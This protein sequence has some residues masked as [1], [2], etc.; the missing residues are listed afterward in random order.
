MSHS[1][2]HFVAFEPVGPNGECYVDLINKI[3]HVTSSIW[4]ARKWHGDIFEEVVIYD[5]I[6]WWKPIKRISLV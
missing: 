5:K 1:K 4:N 2:Y 6:D 3:E